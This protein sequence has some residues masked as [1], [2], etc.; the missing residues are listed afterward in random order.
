MQSTI[1]NRQSTNNNHKAG[2][3]MII[4]VDTGG[5]FTDFVYKDGDRWGVYKVLSTPANPAQAV[6]EGL[7]HLTRGKDRSSLK[8]Q[9]PM[10]K[11]IIHGSTVATNAILERDGARCALITNKGFEDIIEIG[12]QN[13]SRL[14]DLAY[15]KEPHIIPFKLRFG[16]G[17]RM[18]QTGEEL[19]PLD[20][21]TAEDT[22]RHLKELDV[23]SVAVCFL[24]SYVN[25]L[26]EKKMRELLEPLGFQIS[27]SHEILAEF[28]EF[29]RTST[30]VINAYV[31]PKMKR[32][33]GYLIENLGPEDTLAIMQSNGGSIS[34]ETAM[35]ESVRTILSGPAGGAVGA[36]E[37]GKVTGYTTLITFDMGGTSTDVALIDKDLSLTL[38]SCISGY[39]VK[40]PM[41]DIHTVGAGGGSIARLDEAGALKVGP[42]SAGADPGPICYG[43]GENITVTDA[44]LFLG[45]LVPEHFL[46]GKMTLEQ[47]R[48][49]SYFDKMV[50]NT[51][52]T[53]LE[54]AEGI[55]DVT[56]AAMERAIRVI[57]VERGYDPREFTLFSFGGAG[58]MHAAFLARLLNIPKVLFPQNPGIL[59]AIGMLMADV[60]KDYSL[61][62][63]QNQAD[64]AFSSLS[65]MF[66]DIEQK[67]KKDLGAEGISKEKILLERY[68]D[69]R[70]QG[71]S[72]EIIVPFDEDYVEKFHEL[73]EKTYGYRNEDKSIEIVNIRLRARG[74]PEKPEFKKSAAFQKKPADDAFLGESEVV[75]DHERLPTKI[76]A[77][78]KLKSGNRIKGP[79]VV[80][81]YSST[82]VI[83]PF[84]SAYV[85]E[86]GNIVME[87]M[88]K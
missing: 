13:R 1:D 19:M 47:E 55:L 11:K 87:I 68:L 42:G 52:L 40:V 32:Y 31:S 26:H 35:K 43:K 8:K 77:R 50:E 48:L 83:P 88:A 56:N 20:I 10:R 60:I 73:H 65:G 28:R 24:F 51:Q 21:K 72:Y 78:D 46:G 64:A 33:I 57:S 4:G 86:Y 18:L 23:E 76:I 80:V 85:D 22:G 3:S 75:F 2:V 30:T 61:T 39:P 59:S 66:H 25:P 15:R 49:A 17:G 71:Q 69:M 44:N 41:I 45:R 70:Y 7:T 29:E 12:R 54:L 34:V 36:Y 9:H 27:L 82:L 58:G 74:M 67:G 6:L 38:E 14:Y 53:P 37:I 79:A 81:E 63:M 5:T 16:L 84:A 62:V